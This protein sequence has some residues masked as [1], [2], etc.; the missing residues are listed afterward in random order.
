MLFAP[1]STNQGAEVD[2]W[3][4][5]CIVG[6]QI[7]LYLGCV[8]E[9]LAG[10]AHGPRVGTLVYMMGALQV[11]EGWL[12]RVAVAVAVVDS[13]LHDVCVLVLDMT[14]HVMATCA[15]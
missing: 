9:T 2:A 3:V 10:G 14:V 11:W 4:D 12:L 8:A 7:S 6:C 13:R 5:G 15:H 1:A